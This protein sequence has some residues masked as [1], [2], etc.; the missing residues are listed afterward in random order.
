MQHRL[1]EWTYAWA[2]TIEMALLLV[3]VWRLPWY[4][5]LFVF[6]GLWVVILAY[7]FL[8]YKIKWK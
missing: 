3:F 1:N 7:A 6:L 8:M 5:G 2:F 4:M